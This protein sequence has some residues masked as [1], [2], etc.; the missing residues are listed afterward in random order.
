MYKNYKDTL[1]LPNTSFPIKENLSQKEKEIL[2]E[3]KKT[4]LSSR[5]NDR[6]NA[7]RFVLHDG[8]P[9]ANG[10]IHY[11]HILNK[12]LKD[13]VNRSKF[14]SGMS[15][16]MIP[17]WDCHGLPIELAVMRE[18]SKDG[19]RDIPALRAKCK[20]YADSWVETQRQEFERLGIQMSD[21]SY[22]TTDA[23][24]EAA[25][26]RQLAKF[27][28]FDLIY[29]EKKPVHW[30]LSCKTALAEAEIEYKNEHVSPSSYI[31]F[32]LKQDSGASVVIWTT[33]PWTLPGNQ[34]VAFN[35]NAEY[36]II[37]GNNEKYIIASKL[38]DDFVGKCNIDEPKVDGQPL[39]LRISFELSDIELEHPF[40]KRYVNLVPSDHVTDDSGTGFVHIAPGYGPEDYL[41]GKKYNLPIETPITDGGLHISGLWNG[42][43]IWKSN[44]LILEHLASTNTL[45][46][47]ASDAIKHSHAVCWR[48]KNPVIYL[49]TNQW[50]AS[51]DKPFNNGKTLRQIA[52]ESIDKVNWI[53]K[54]GID[55]IRGMLTNRPDWVLS[56]QRSWGVP[57]PVFYKDGKPLH[58]S[59]DEMSEIMN[60]VANLMDKAG[61]NIWFELSANELLPEKYRQ[62]GITKGNDIADVWFESGVSWA[63]VAH[64]YNGQEGESFVADLYLEGSDQHRGWFHS[65]LLTAGVANGSAPYRAVLTHGFVLDE[66]GR[67]Y[68]KSE[69]EKARA[70]GIKTE[71]V[72]PDEVINKY[73]A[74]MLRL[75]AASS[76]F[77]QDV[78]YSKKHIENV[79]GGYAKIRNTLRYMLG[80][81]NGFNPNIEHPIDWD[82]PDVLLDRYTLYLTQ[83]IYE[84]CKK[85]YVE[86]AFHK[87]VKEISDFCITYLSPIY[88]DIRKDR[89]YCDDKES[90][91]YKASAY[92][93]YF[94]LRVLNS[95]LAP[96]TCFTSENIWRHMSKLNN[97]P[98]SVHE[99]IWQEGICPLNTNA[100]YSAI[101]VALEARKRV[102]N[103]LEPF[104]KQKHKTTDAIIH[105]VCHE[106]YGALMSI[107]HLLADIFVVSG[108]NLSHSSSS[109]IEVSSASG[110]MCERCYKYQSASLCL[111]CQPFG[112]KE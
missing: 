80:V 27:A 100:D 32:R 92:T 57:I 6:K 40:E 79:S 68:S 83:G 78:T 81:S 15:A 112:S 63:G 70:A 89:V 94:V 23:R 26:V 87:V 37:S 36:V 76:E 104:R 73:G 33:T 5:L 20:A 46:S 108:V 103:A 56:R 61:S 62:D 111:R 66:R 24:Y 45:L 28:G 59:S 99:L 96:I 55:R 71:Y 21:T 58:G 64:L 74:E 3:W 106:E 105:I 53:P 44:K 69:I 16:H 77:T 75:W 93:M 25:I 47:Q 91:A 14:M 52:L 30:C 88:F 38:A 51:L 67:P 54:W 7:P 18:M 109:S 43:H 1:N 110:I 86:Y 49:A 2:E 42:Q 102:N 50:F 39:R 72:S 65:S 11:G 34:A 48:C 84:R 98:L 107:K 101:I 90:E 8:P 12:S 13:I 22:L 9:Y 60:Y 41:V 82:S 85:H 10:H 97:D 95:L 17:G 19:A 29:R 31:K 4:E 35:P